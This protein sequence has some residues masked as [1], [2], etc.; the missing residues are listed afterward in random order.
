MKNLLRSHGTFL[1]VVIA[2]LALLGY[3]RDYLFVY[4]NF[5]LFKLYSPPDYPFSLPENLRFLENFSYTQLYYGKY[6]L[7]AAFCLIYFGITWLTLKK[8]FNDPSLFRWTVWIH[9]AILALG[10]LFYFYGVL[11]NDRENGYSLSLLFMHVLQSPVVLMI[12]V[13]LFKLA[14][15]SRE[16]GS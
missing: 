11:F 12:L 3:L 10:V 4:I 7:T 2:S 1:A 6:G 16:Q 5:Q 9:A 8:L 13:P 15:M 14:R